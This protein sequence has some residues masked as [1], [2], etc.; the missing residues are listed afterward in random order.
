MA[1][2]SKRGNLEYERKNK[3][4]D[5]ANSHNG[6]GFTLVELLVVVA[7]I[8]ILA[9][10]L[11]PVLAKA[12]ASAQSA[13]CKNNLRQ[14]GIALIMYVD[15]YGKYP[16]NTAYFQGSRLMSFGGTGM[17]WLKSYF[18]DRYKRFVGVDYD[19]GIPNYRDVFNCPARP[20]SR[21]PD[22]RSIIYKQGYGYNALGTA[23]HGIPQS[24]RALGLGRIWRG[25]TDFDGR[26]ISDDTLEVSPY[27]IQAPSQMIAIGDTKHEL[28]DAVSPYFFPEDNHFYAIGNVH[29]GG[30]NVV[31]C[32]GH[33]EYA[34]Q[35]KWM[36]AT[37]TGRRR[38]NNDN[39]PHPETW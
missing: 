21:G 23:W 33:V 38:W 3:P 14:Q 13:A 35:S 5:K 4:L 36:E 31:F 7:V 39:Q 8:A 37:E 18:I 26:L 6:R 11:L 25:R 20:F 34:R 1:T 19:V 29:H 2:R 28:A 30:A 22:G 16:G 9:A 17:I 10:L 24:Q 27:M 15:D 12:K 32:D